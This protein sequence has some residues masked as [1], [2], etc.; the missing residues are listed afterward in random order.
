M[1]TRQ[2]MRNLCFSNKSSWVFISKSWVLVENFPNSFW[3]SLN[4]KVFAVNDRTSLAPNLW[5][6]CASNLYQSLC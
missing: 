1:E 3:T 5:C 6:L 2:V 4:L